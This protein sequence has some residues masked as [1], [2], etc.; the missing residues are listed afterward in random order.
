MNKLEKR[1][2]AAEQHEF[3]VLGTNQVDG[4][5]TKLHVSVHG[6][7]DNVVEGWISHDAYLKC[8]AKA[9]RRTRNSAEARDW[10]R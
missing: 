5:I 4:Q 10:R 1:L 7:N 6:G 3:T 8:R 2:A 9:I